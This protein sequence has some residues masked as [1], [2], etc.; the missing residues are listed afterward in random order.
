V[1]KDAPPELAEIVN[2][3]LRKDPA[4]RYQ[5]MADVKL[6]AEELL[7]RIATGQTASVRR[8]A[9]QEEKSIAVL[10]FADM[11]PQK[12]QEYFCDGIAEE[13]LNALAQL[14]CVR[15][16]SR[17]SAFQFKARS[18]DIRKIGAQLNVTTVLEGSVRKSG[19]RLRISAQ[20][21]NVADG[22]Q[23]WSERFDRE[24]KDVFEIQDEIS[25]A[26]VGKL[27]ITLTPGTACQIVRRPTDDLEAYQLYLKG[28]FYWNQWTIEGVQAGITFFEKAI[29][30]DPEY[31]LAYAGLADCYTVL[32][33]FGYI[34]PGECYPRAR[35]AA[36]KA[37]E[38]DETLA[39]AHASLGIALCFSE[40][41]W[42]EAEQHFQRAL[43]IN[44]NMAGAYH[45]Y[46]M[47]CL[48]PQGRLEE[49]YKVVA[50]GADLDPHS[51]S[52][53]LALGS[54]EAFRG[55]VDG[56]LQRFDALKKMA[57]NFYLAYFHASS[58]YG[59]KGDFTAATAELERARQLSH[60]D[61]RVLASLGHY[62][63][64]L[65]RTAE[66]QAC[67]AELEELARVRYMQRVNF[68]LVWIGLGEIDRA[69]EDIEQSIEAHDGWVAFL[70]LD[71]KFKALRGHPRYPEL[72]GR[73]GLTS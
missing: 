57:P 67:L 28:R 15:V 32:G 23:L 71:P 7:A 10:A 72:L 22:Y 69:M 5:S 25:M 30:R 46:G 45:A 49:A 27:K 40:W 64:L 31:A 20:L 60:A 63:G 36:R 8:E 58:A 43:K 13:I 1:L 55:D 50:R 29:A 62:Y 33:G 9:V 2:R 73:M 16:A 44:P 12:D 56:A 59:A 3:C 26:I 65:G 51:I 19:E 66:A 53:A 34:A 42:K 48:A 11:S 21:I 41:N 54:V 68:A 17:T 18:D 24:M 4:R 35:E 37:L 39:E 6:S 47:G 61:P 70:N 52:I 14:P 38:L